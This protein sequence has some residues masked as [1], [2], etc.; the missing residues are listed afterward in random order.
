[1]TKFMR[2]ILALFLL[3]AMCLSL[4]TTAFAA[5]TIDK[6][7][8]A[9][10]EKKPDG[11]YV[12]YDASSDITVKS[13][14]LPNGNC[15]FEQYQ[16]SKLTYKYVVNRAD[17]IINSTYYVDSGKVVNE[18]IVVPIDKVVN[19]TNRSVSGAYMGIVR[20]QYTSGDQSG[21]CGA[22]VNYTK[23][24]GS[25]KYNINGTY[26][27][28]AGLAATIASLLALPSGVATSVAKVVMG[29]LGIGL[30]VLSFIIP[31]C[32]LN[33]NYEEIEYDL[34]NINNHLHTN[35]FYGT[36]YIITEAGTHIDD[37][38]TDGTYY[39]TTSWGNFN[40]G[41]TIYNHMFNYSSWSIYSWS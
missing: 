9:M 20:Y 33:S 39:P 13:Y 6:A 37:V 12:L 28:L 14:D 25:K 38:Y 5:E 11:S 40:F 8:N 31:D 36:K 24:T 7:N 30:G 22:S 10:V 26:Q 27:S 32:N 29:R 41:S 1:M 4:G 18:S 3:V 16:G 21:I 34:E 2:S 35:S 17:G 19:T 23:R 15:I